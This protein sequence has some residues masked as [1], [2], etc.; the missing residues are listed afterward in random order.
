MI[1][2]FLTLF[3]ILHGWLEQDE[4]MTVWSR[5]LYPDIFNYLMFYL[6]QPGSTDL[7]D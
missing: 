5:L 4:G 6:I 2:L 7:S 3:E 1:H